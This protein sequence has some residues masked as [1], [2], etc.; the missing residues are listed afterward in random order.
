MQQRN[1]TCLDTKYQYK[2]YDNIVNSTRKY[3]VCI[4]TTSGQKNLASTKEVDDKK[5][6]G[7]NYQFALGPF[8]L[9]GE[10]DV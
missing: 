3:I 1:T 2:L 6:N 7:N 9:N 8:L 5:K 4:L 10:E